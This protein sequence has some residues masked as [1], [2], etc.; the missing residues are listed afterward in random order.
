MLEKFGVHISWLG[1]GGGKT[2]GKG[3]V[4]GATNGMKLEERRISEQK[5]GGS[6]DDQS[7]AVLPQLQLPLDM[8]LVLVLVQDNSVALSSASGSSNNK[9]RLLQPPTTPSEYLRTLDLAKRR[10]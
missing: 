9:N 2:V 5:Q 8:A 4:A 3:K 6:S 7:P 10:E 1:A